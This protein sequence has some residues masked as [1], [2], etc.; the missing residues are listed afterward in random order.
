MNYVIDAFA[1]IFDPAN[2]TGPSGILTL[3]GEHLYIT[4][5]VVLIASAIAVPL[6]YLI[7]HTGK[8]KGF[9]VALSGAVRALPTLGLLTIVALST[10]IGLTAPLVALTVLAI[11]PI[12]AGAYSGFEAVDR[13]TIDAAR[14]MG[15]T[16]WQIVRK[17]EIPLGLPLLISGLRS[18]VLQVVATATLAAI[19]GSGGLGRPIF[20]GLNT[21]NYPLMIVGSILVIALALVLDGLFALAQRAFVPAGVRLASANRSSRARPRRPRAVV[22]ATTE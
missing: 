4:L 21:Q 5:L 22:A 3:V 19:T 15:M 18:T 1:Y 13:K 7:G 8:G 9:A 12:L 6:G 2:A 11:P 16:E 17:V 14:A 20:V 10:G